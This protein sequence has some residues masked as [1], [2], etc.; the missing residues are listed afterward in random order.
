MKICQIGVEL[1]HADRPMNMTKLTD[2]FHDF[3]D[4]PHKELHSSKSSDTE[5]TT[6][7]I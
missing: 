3:A 6:L 7:V 1:F 5:K 2:N 4:A